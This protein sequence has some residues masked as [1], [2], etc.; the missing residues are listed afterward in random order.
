MGSATVQMF[1]WFQIIALKNMYDNDMFPEKIGIV[2]ETGN[3]IVEYK[4]SGIDRNGNIYTE[5]KTIG[6][7]HKEPNESF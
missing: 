7:P 1:S 4:E 2:Q 6:I 3:L 5:M